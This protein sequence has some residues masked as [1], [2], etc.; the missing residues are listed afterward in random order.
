MV[1]PVNVLGFGSLGTV[2]EGPV[3][4]WVSNYYGWSSMFT[5]M[6]VLTIV[7]ALATIKASISLDNRKS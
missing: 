6:V 5:M 4:A 1:S 2:L 7:G 3:I